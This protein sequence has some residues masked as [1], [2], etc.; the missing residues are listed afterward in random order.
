[1]DQL[2]AELEIELEQ[3]YLNIEEENSWLLAIEV[4]FI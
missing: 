4:F 3:L 1:M 2:A